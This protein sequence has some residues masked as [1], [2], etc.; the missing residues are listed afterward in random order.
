MYK[1]RL[2]LVTLNHKAN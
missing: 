2:D 1:Q